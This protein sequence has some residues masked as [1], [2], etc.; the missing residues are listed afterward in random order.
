MLIRTRGLGWLK[1]E[2]RTGVTYPV[3]SIPVWV[4]VLLLFT[5]FLVTT[6]RLLFVH[7]SEQGSSPSFL[8]FTTHLNFFCFVFFCLPFFFLR[9]FVFRAPPGHA[10]P[11]LV[12]WHWRFRRFPGPASPLSW[13]APLGC[14]G[15]T[16]ALARAPASGPRWTHRHGTPV[17]GGLYGWFV[18]M[19]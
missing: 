17:G 6:R 12:R 18:L 1:S 9:G 11:T 13:L 16:G 15:G 10:R 2:E 14:R 4:A 3:F 19:R 8:A 5:A 7:V